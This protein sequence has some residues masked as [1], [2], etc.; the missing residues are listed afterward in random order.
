MFRRHFKDRLEKI[1]VGYTGGSAS[2][3]SYRQVCSGDTGHAEAVQIL[4]D[5]NKVRYEELVEFF[6]AMHD[7]TTMNRQGPDTGS[8]Y[9]SALYYYNGEQKK[10]AEQVTQQVQE[11]H[12][13]GKKIV[14]QIV[15]ADKFW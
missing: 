10:I 13:Q 2:A 1:R 9:R 7:P 14:T 6:Y 3:P 15:A 4:Y 5:P 12:F 8:Q 11:E